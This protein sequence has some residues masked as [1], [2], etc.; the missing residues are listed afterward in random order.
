MYRD[1]EFHLVAHWASTCSDRISQVAS[2]H[3]RLMDCLQPVSSQLGML[4]WL[5]NEGKPAPSR[6]FAD[7]RILF[8]ARGDRKGFVPAIVQQSNCISCLVN[9][10]ILKAMVEFHNQL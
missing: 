3:S 8:G 5:L 2:I 7:E 9:T 1:V 4:L 6:P 10:D